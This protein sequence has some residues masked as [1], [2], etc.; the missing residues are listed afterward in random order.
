MFFP[1]PPRKEPPESGKPA[2]TP[3]PPASEGVTSSE[4][5]E[6]GIPTGTVRAWGCTGAIA[7]ASF[8]LLIVYATLA[9]SWVPG[10][11]D[12]DALLAAVVCCCGF[13]AGSGGLFG[14][15]VGRWAGRSCAEFGREP[16]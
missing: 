8:G 1:V 3:P 6:S 2:G 10:D 14:Y 9:G 11:A 15:L 7:G 4:P 13:W 5:P 16:G 12:G